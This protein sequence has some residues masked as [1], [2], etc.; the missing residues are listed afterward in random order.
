LESS[1]KEK[2]WTKD[3]IIISVASFLL[4]MIF[5][6]L[7]VTIVPY[8]IETFDA[9][10]GQAGFISGLFIIGVLIGR[11][12][13]G[14]KL[15]DFDTRKVMMIGSGLFAG[16]IL[17]YF[18]QQGIVFLLF[19]RFLHGLSFGIATT[20]MSTII[21]VILPN[22]RKGEGIGYYSMSITLATAIGPFIGIMMIKYASYFGIFSLCFI[23]GLFSVVIIFMSK[24][25]S[26]KQERKPEE[27]K[28]S[29]DQF[30]EPKAF[31]IA[32][33]IIGVSF[34]YASILSFINLYAAEINLVEAASVF[35]LVYAVTILISR[36]ITGRIVDL[37]GANYVMYPCIALLAIG[38]VV[39]SMAHNSFMFLLAAALI[40][41]GFGNIQSTAQVVAINMTTP[42][43]MGLATSTYYIAMDAAFGFSPS[44][45]GIILPSLG[46]RNMYLSLAVLA[47]S[48][49]VVYYFVYG[50]KEK[51]LKSAS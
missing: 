41:I 38:M 8:A 16:S 46:Y 32:I 18:I 6:L 27:R 25:P 17:L 21:A 12:Y 42:E 7:M 33:I 35:F 3:F 22:S 2:L 26:L 45:L 13:I 47:M 34:C 36:P 5:Y 24:I 9:S 15:V 50:R 28:L 30:V 23:L 4:A 39:L 49:M 29:L 14:R 51:I 10:T 37:I 31:P 11:L 20:A 48:M 44:F 43:R 1:K 40:G 19:S